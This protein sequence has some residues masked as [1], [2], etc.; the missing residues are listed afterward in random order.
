MVCRAYVHFSLVWRIL[1]LKL[2]QTEWN[3]NKNSEW[4]MEWCIECI[5]AYHKSFSSFTVCLE[6]RVNTFKRE[7]NSHIHLH[8]SLL[9]NIWKRI[10]FEACAA[11]T[12]K[13]SNSVYM[14]WQ[15]DMLTLAKKEKKNTKQ[16]KAYTEDRNV[17]HSIK[18]NVYIEILQR[19]QNGYFRCWCR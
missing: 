5:L 16:K 4:K 2:T 10:S 11:L 7:Q 13:F 15:I 8:K 3:K 17:S 6:N 19:L 18:S 1:Q 14:A 9:M 12:F